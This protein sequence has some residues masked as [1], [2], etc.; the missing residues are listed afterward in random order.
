MYGELHIHDREDPE[1]V[2]TVIKP[3][4]MAVKIYNGEYQTG[5]ISGNTDTTVTLPVP[6]DATE[7]LAVIPFGTTPS[8]YH[9]TE[10]RINAC[11]VQ[12][13]TVGL[14][15]VGSNSQTYTVRYTVLYR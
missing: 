11:N 9:E 14:R 15:T 8:A 13:H 5:T 10:A 2:Y 3:E 7:I 6:S 12:N 1:N 4:E